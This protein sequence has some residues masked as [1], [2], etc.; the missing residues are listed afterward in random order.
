VDRYLRAR[1]AGA[2]RA[3]A[4]AGDGPVA[5]GGSRFAGAG[6]TEVVGAREAAG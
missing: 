4:R 5:L 3:K 2:R 6:I 1:L